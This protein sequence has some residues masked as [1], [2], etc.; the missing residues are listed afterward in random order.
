MQRT[1]TYM[2]YKLSVDGIS[3]TD[4]KVEAIKVCPNTRKCLRYSSWQDSRKGVEFHT[5]W[6]EH[7]GMP[8]SRSQTLLHMMSWTLNWTGLPYLGIE[9]Y[10]PSKPDRTNSEG[11]PLVSSWS[12]QNEVHGSEP[13]VVAQV[14]CWS[15][16]DYPC[17]PAVFQDT[18]RTTCSTPLPM[19]MALWPLEESPRWFCHFWRET[20]PYP[21]RCVL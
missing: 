21:G 17:M 2:G 15:W 4:E 8:W 3:P 7:S 19:D 16:A 13:C 12:G 6:L 9:S 14:R 1:V 10:H 11:A 20:L 18:E 5:E